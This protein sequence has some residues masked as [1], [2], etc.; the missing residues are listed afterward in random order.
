[1]SAFL[2]VWSLREALQTR[3]G[4]LRAG[5]FPAHEE[6]DKHWH[7]VC[8]SRDVTILGRIDFRNDKRVFGIK[9]GGRFAH[10]YAIGKT[11]TGKSTLLEEMAL[12]DLANGN[13]FALIDPLGDLAEQVASRVPPS[14]RDDLIYLNAADVNQP[15][16]YNPLRRVAPQYIALAASG[17]MEVFKKSMPPRCGC[18]RA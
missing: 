18:T 1:M 14:R 6:S 17:F 8:M 13:G 3:R 9:R 11:G 10:V 4:N 15:W 16:G 2:V 7:T 5:K 12:Q